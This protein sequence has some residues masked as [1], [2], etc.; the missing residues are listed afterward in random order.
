MTELIEDVA[1]DPDRVTRIENALGSRGLSLARTGS[2]EDRLRAVEA[3]VGGLGIVAYGVD[4]LETTIAG[5]GSRLDDFNTPGQE[6]ER[7]ARVE[8]E[9]A[10][11]DAA[12][13]AAQTAQDEAAKQAALE[14]QVAAEQA[15]AA[16]RQ[17]LLEAQ[18]AQLVADADQKENEAVIARERADAAQAALAAGT[19]S[20]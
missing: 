10:A 6:A 3:A 9:K 7:L 12:A 2:V 8:A 17:Q 18:A 19:E 4:E 11:A 5:L 16:Q 15:A 20:A 13:K 14:Q 1:V